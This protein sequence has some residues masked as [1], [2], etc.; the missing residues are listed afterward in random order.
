MGFIIL[1]KNIQFS[2]IPI[3]VMKLQEHQAG[4]W[5]SS[6]YKLQG[7]LSGC[8]GFVYICM[9]KI[10]ASFHKLE[11]CYDNHLNI[12]RSITLDVIPLLD[13]GMILRQLSGVDL[14]GMPPVA[15]KYSTT[16]Q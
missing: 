16:A 2:F 7:S 12:I 9:K 14:D 5:Q 13:L 6:S 3:N 10:N 8:L 4:A 1:S 15:Q 11:N